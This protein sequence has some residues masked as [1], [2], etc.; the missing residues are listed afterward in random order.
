[1]GLRASITNRFLERPFR[2]LSA[3]QMAERLELDGR[4]L[5]RTFAAAKDSDHNRTL[6]SHISGIESWGQSRLQ[7]AL[8]APLL[9][10]EYDGYRPAREASWIELEDAFR[11]TRQQTVALARQLGPAVEAGVYVP[12]NQ[13]GPL[14]VR[15]WLRYLDMHATL[16]AKKLSS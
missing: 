3:E 8:G 12:H 2:N 5:E 14:T 11:N 4:T 1:M 13:F 15:S 10:D 7:V 6:L 16:E 9:M